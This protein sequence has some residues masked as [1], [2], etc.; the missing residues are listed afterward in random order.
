MAWVCWKRKVS[1]STDAK[2]WKHFT[3]MPNTNWISHKRWV[4]H[5]YSVH[6]IDFIRQCIWFRMNDFQWHRTRGKAIK[7]ILFVRSNNQLLWS[8][9]DFHFFLVMNKSARWLP[10]AAAGSRWLWIIKKIF[11]RL[12][13]GRH[14]RSF[15]RHKKW[16]PNRASSKKMNCS[17][18][19]Q[20]K[21]HRSI[22]TSWIWKMKRNK[23]VA[24][25]WHSMESQFKVNFLFCLS[26]FQLRHELDRVR[27][28]RD[29]MLQEN[30]EIGRDKSDADA[31]KLRL[32]VI[33]LK[34]SCNS[35]RI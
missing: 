18:N 21:K 16:R 24:A 2:N 11:M 17:M 10:A 19:R 5:I 8:L 3:R 26:C 33:L 31:E 7:K 6:D 13:F 15:K 4:L 27:N 32:K 29:R 14:W 20:Q 25:D 30:S 22:C 9:D 1:C 34:M 28:E 35:M 23:W 12:I